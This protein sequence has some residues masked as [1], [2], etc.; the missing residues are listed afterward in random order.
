[1][2]F[3]ILKDKFVEG[4]MLYLHF[5]WHTVDHQAKC[6]A[7]STLHRGNNLLETEF[8]SELE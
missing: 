3:N 5:N 4:K 1:M 8:H 7:A 6:R 2:Q